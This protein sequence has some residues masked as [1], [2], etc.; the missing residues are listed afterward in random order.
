VNPVTAAAVEAIAA[1]GWRGRDTLRLGGWLVRAA[2][3]WTGRANSVLPLGEP[4]RPLDEAI[5]IVT[6]WYA[7]RGLSP[8]FQVPLP[9]SADLDDAL[10]ARGWTAYNPTFFLVAELGPI[11]ALLP[12]LDDDAV[13]VAPEPSEGW[14]A[15]YHY[16]GGALPTVARDVLVDADAPAFASVIR[17]GHMLAIGRAVV[18]D[19]WCG[20][21]AL[22][23]EPAARRRGLARVVLAGLLDWAAARGATAIYLQV[24]EDNEAALALY[25]G[26]GFAEHHRYHY[27]IAPDA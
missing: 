25:R 20:I 19:E 9:L 2:E 21:T 18:D 22:E 8:R 1:R 15:A 3:G 13:S 26:L 16:R 7:E 17:D 14:L 23:V 27:R 5:E 6:R 12:V 24:A 11:R 4:Q 10:A